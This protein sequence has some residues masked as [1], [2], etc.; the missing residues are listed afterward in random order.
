M[1]ALVTGGAGFIGSHL[2]DLLLE[3]KFEVIVLDNF[4][5]GRALNLDHVEKKIDLVECD[6]SVQGDW[7]KKFQSVDYVFHLA[8]L[9]DIVPSIQNPE[10]YFQSNVTGTLNVLQAS[11]HQNVKRFVYAASSSCYGIPEVYPTPE[12]SPIQP[13][14]PYALTKRMG[15]ELVIHWAQVYKFPALSLRFFN[16]YGPRSRTSGTYGAVFGVFLAQKLAE[17][18]FTVVGDGKQ[19]R[20]FTYVRDVVEAVFAAAQSDKVGEIYNVG[21]GATISVNRIVELLKGE[22]TYIPKRPG[23][24]DSTFA[25]I[26]KIKKDLKWSPKISIETG[27]GELLK[28]INYWREAPVWTPDKI[29]KATSDWFKYLGGSNS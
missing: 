5:T 12:T 6:I 29:E 17:K 11:R 20:D 25:D 22:V 3:N 15:E 7:I 16:V 13:Q 9:A 2:V 10:G 24:P 1:K 23:E 8:A 21:S 18:P 14:Y 19:T 27:I 28:N 4:S 26:T